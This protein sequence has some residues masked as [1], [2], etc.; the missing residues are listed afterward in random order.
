[1]NP[2]PFIVK[3]GVA[4]LVLA[5]VLST[6]YLWL[7]SKTWGAGAEMLWWMWPLLAIVNALYVLLLIL[8]WR[9][10]NWARWV[11]VVWCAVSWVLTLSTT[12]LVDAT[13]TDRFVH[14]TAIAAEVWAFTQ[15][16]SKASSPWFHA[17]AAS[18]GWLSVSSSRVLRLVLCSAAAS[19]ASVVVVIIA[20]ILFPVRTE[21]TPL[22]VQPG[23]TYSWEELEEAR[24]AMDERLKARHEE[25]K[26][27]SFLEHV[28]ETKRH[29]TFISWLPW[30]LVGFGV[31]IRSASDVLV[32]LSVPAV[33]AFVGVVWVGEL[34]TYGAGI[35]IG[36]LA[37]RYA[38]ARPGAGDP[39]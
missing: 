7:D 25:D 39:S 37:R 36:W 18:R 12:N 8:V 17:P 4:V 9:G 31:S 22:Q 28:T 32:L 34:P 23:R 26:R 15:I 6:A 2:T 27:R 1:M 3:Q 24:R 35:F 30:L 10:R 21:G 13:A 14:F 11:V 16:F 5:Q 19:V 20:L 29:W 33:L 38:N